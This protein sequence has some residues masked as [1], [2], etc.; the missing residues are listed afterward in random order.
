MSG[1]SEQSALC[2]A[3]SG[4]L[5]GVDVGLTN[6]VALLRRPDGRSSPLLFDG[7]PVL[8][9]GVLLDADGTVLV[10]REAERA[11]A[12]DPHHFEPAPRRHIAEQK[13]RLGE[14][15]TTPTDLLAGVL[16]A[17]AA[18]AIATLGTVPPTAL[19]YPVRWGAAEQKTLRDAALHAGFTDVTLIPEP[20]AAVAAVGASMAVER[21][22]AV[23]DIGA[24]GFDVAVLAPVSG[25]LAVVAVGGDPTIGGRRIDAA[26]AAH[27]A[28]AAGRQ[29]RDIWRAIDR[30]RTVDQRRAQRQFWADVRAAKE[31]LD[32]AAFVPVSVPGTADIV[33]LARADMERFAGPVADRVARVT[34]RVLREAGVKPQELDAVVLVGGSAPLPTLWTTMRDTLGVEPVQ[35]EPPAFAMAGGALGR[36][37]ADLALPVGSPLATAAMGVPHPPRVVPPPRLPVA[38]GAFTRVAKAA[39][40]LVR[41]PVAEIAAPPRRAALPGP[42]QPEDGLPGLSA[43]PAPRRAPAVPEPRRVQHVPAHRDPSQPYERATVAWTRFGWAL[44]LVAILAVL[45]VAM[46]VLLG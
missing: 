44:V 30:P 3:A 14:R 24:R 21:R 25:R 26:I 6:T 32:E 38:G 33:P 8:P 41:R 19:T 18:S 5:L 13:F 16:G 7:E 45:C 1:S 15:D 23:V 12:T 20:V 35:P 37:A 31:A 9:S 28:A 34:A 43:L 36:L 39:A 17:V 42:R 29:R 10:G 40:R 11:A 4:P 2:P 46:A 27:I 22:L